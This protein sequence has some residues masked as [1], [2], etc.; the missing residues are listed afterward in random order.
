MDLIEIIIQIILYL[1]KKQTNYNYMTLYCCHRINTV[2]ELKKIPHKY[3]IEIDLRDN[4]NGDIYISHDPFKSGENF[5]EFLKYYRH[6]F[7][8]LNIKSERIEY[9]VLELLKK[10]NITNYFFLDSSFPMI[11]KLSNAGEKN[12]A[13]RF[14]EFEGLDMI[15]AMKSKVD[16]VWV[17]CFTKNPLNKE[18][19]KILKE[20]GFKLCFVSPELQQQP[21]KIYEYKDYFDK[22]NIEL[23]MI[24]SKYYNIDKWNNT[25][26]EVQIIIPM[27]GLGQRF[28]NAG[29]NIPKPL[30]VVDNKPIIEH[31]V[32]LFTGENNIK[33]ICNNEHLTETNMRKILN[34]FCPHGKIY[35]VPVEGRYGPV[36]AVSLIF[37]SID[38]DKEVIV[39]Y[40]DY[41]TWWD[42]QGFLKDTRERNADGAIACYKGFHPHMLGADNY[43]FLKETYTDSRWMSAIQEKMPFTNNKMNEY[44]SNGTYYFKTGAIM[45]KYFQELMDLEM[46]VKNEY[47]VSMVYNLLVRDKLSVNIFEIEHMLQWGTPNDLEIYKDWSRYF[48]NIIKPQ[49]KFIDNNNTTTLLPLAGRGSR[50]VKKGYNVPK[51]LIDVSNKPMIVQAV[52]CIPKS[53]NFTFICLKEHI[54]K[55]NLKQELSKNYNNPKIV[56]IDKV[57]EGQACTCE[58]GLNSTKFDLEQSILISACDNGVYYDVDKYQ[59]LVDDD[60]VDVIVWSF[61]NNSTSKNNPNMY[62]WMDVDENDNIRSVSCK[63]F[64]K[65]IHDIKKSHVIIGT[66]FFRKAKYFVGG[67]QKNYKENKR[68]NNEFYV[69]DVINQN[70]KDGLNVKVFEVDNYICW[71]TP[72][73][74]ETYK[75][76]QDFF[77]KCNWHPYHKEL[78]ITYDTSKI[79]RS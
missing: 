77:H 64:V 32:N 31:V 20:A 48:E 9:K 10:Y 34:S 71:G 13:I 28:V 79:I 19:Y 57:T 76:W 45:K 11:Y 75:Y 29:Y 16:W 52:N 33:F 3:G 2:E 5:D 23:D 44:A 1:F 6:S 53:S 35:E 74:Y 38:D 50:F 65:E 24:C 14:S 22:N 69:D 4:L 39:S 17:D 41:G 47:Y 61:K 37:D 18:N 43:A 51:P 55:Y 46:K 42:Y 59:Q 49:S 73:D 21:E 63:K 26:K 7:I 60:S 62:A 36:H 15:L 8:I 67:L 12:C 25:K 68:T 40:C 56:I 78:D 70:I 27:S 66:M 72:D 54:E 30:I 58:L